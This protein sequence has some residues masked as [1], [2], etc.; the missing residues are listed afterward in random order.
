MSWTFDNNLP[1]YLQ[2][3]DRIK[4]Q[5]ISNQ[6]HA[7]EKLPA[8]REL[9]AEAGVNP[10]TIQRALSDL[11]KEGFVYSKRTSGRFVTDNRDL[12]LQARQKLSEEEVRKFVE[13]MTRF[14]YH[15]EE[16]PTIIA[17]YIKG[18]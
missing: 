11:E 4:L 16:L 17:D 8:V 10:N 6:L 15:K 1:I 3:M 2:I 18:V 14:G 13:N 9:A 5:I 12:I 7:G